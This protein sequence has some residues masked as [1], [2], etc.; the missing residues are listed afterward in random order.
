MN[1]PKEWDDLPPKER[2]KKIKKLKKEQERLAEQKQAKKN[3]I[4]F[5]AGASVVFALIAYAIVMTVMKNT[6]TIEGLAEYNIRD[7]K[8]VNTEVDYPQSPP[9]GGDHHPNWVS[10][11]G[12]V[13]DE[14]LD[15]ERAV[16]ALEHGAV[17]ITY[18][19]GELSKED[20]DSLEKK[21]KNYTFMSPYSDQDAPLVLTAWGYQLELE[22]AQDPRVDFFIDKFRQ[23]PQTPEPGATCNTNGF[24]M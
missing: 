19:E 21:I 3:K 6:R 20:L 16:H 18:K 9:V 2:K 4:L 11:N 1:Y 17:W 10:C 14:E 5:I 24:G 12:D 23:G 7:W 8:H 13:Y 22:D 15:L